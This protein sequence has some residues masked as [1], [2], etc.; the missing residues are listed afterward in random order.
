MKKNTIY[1]LFFFCLITCTLPTSSQAGHNSNFD[2]NTRLLYWVGGAGDWTDPLHWSLSSGGTGGQ[3]PPTSEDDVVFDGQSGFVPGD[4]VAVGANLQACKS[5]DWH[6]VTGMPVF[7]SMYPINVYGSLHLSANM[8]ITSG[9]FFFQAQSG[10]HDITTE[11]QNMGS[12]AFL[13]IGNTW[14][15]QDAF[16]ADFVN[17]GYGTI[18]TNN[19]TVTVGRW[20][21]SNVEAF[22]PNMELFLGTSNLIVANTAD[23]VILFY[24]PGKC[25][26]ENADL[27]FQHGGTLIAE[28][29]IFFQ[30]I[31]FLDATQTGYLNEGNV[32]GKLLF[33]GYGVIHYYGPHFIHEAEFQQGGAFYGS[34]TFDV[35]TLTPGR[36]YLFFGGSTQ[37]ITPGGTINGL[38]GVDCTDRMY[39]HSMVNGQPAYLYKD[40]ADLVFNWLDVRDISVS[41]S[42]QFIANNSAIYGSSAGWTSNY[43]P[44]KL[45]WVNGSGNWSDIS[46]WEDEFGVGNQCPPTALDNVFFDQNSGLSG[47]G[48]IT[49]DVT[50]TCKNLDFTGTTGNPLL[51]FNN[52]LS[53]YGSLTLVTDMQ[54]ALPNWVFGST[55]PG[56]TI[57]S[58]GHNLG[59]VQFLGIGG[60]WTFQ[61]PLEADYVNHGY[62]TIFTN[63]HSVTTGNWQR[64][65]P[66]AFNPYTELFL[67]SST[68]TITSP[69]TQVVLFYAIGKCHSENADLIFEHG[70]TLVAEDGVTFH[71]ISFLDPNYQGFLNEGNVTGKLLFEGYGA[72]YYFGP[73]IIHEAEFQQDGAFYG[74]STFDI[75][76]LTPGKSYLFNSNT[77]QT[78]T[79]CGLLDAVGTSSDPIQMS[80][81]N[82]GE[83]AIIEKNGIRLCVD[84]VNMS[85]IHKSGT[86]PFFA[87][88]NSTDGGNNAGWNFS[89]CPAFGVPVPELCDGIDN[90]CDGDVDEGLSVSL[91]LD[92][93]YDCLSPGENIEIIWSGGCPNWTVDLTLYRISP[94]VA[95]T[96]IA[97]NIPNT[98]SFAWTIPGGVSLSD[99]H[100]YIKKSTAPVVDDYG[101]SFTINNAAS[102]Y[103]DADGDG[104]GDPNNAVEACTSPIGYVADNTDCDDGND[105]VY[106]GSGQPSPVCISNRIVSIAANGSYQL[107]PGQLLLAGELPCGATASLDV[108]DF[109]CADVTTIL[110]P[111]QNYSLAFDGTNEFVSIA[112]PFSGTGNY[113]VEAWFKSENTGNCS[114][115][116]TYKRLLGWGTAQLE[117]ADCGGIL[118]FRAGGLWQSTTVN[119]RDNIWHHVAAV[120]QGNRHIV[121]VDGVKKLDFSQTPAN[122][123]GSFYIGRGSSGSALWK[124][125]IDECRVW[126]IARSQADILGW[127]NKPLP[128]AQAGL[129]GYWNF[130]GGPGSSSLLSN[131]GGPSGVMANM[132]PALDWFGGA[133]LQY[134]APIPVVATINDGGSITTCAS[135]ITV[136]DAQAPVLQC[137]STYTVFPGTAINVLDLLDNPTTDNCGILFQG[138]D[139]GSFTCAEIGVQNVTVT[140]VDINSNQATC[141]VPVTVQD[142]FQYSC[143]DAVKELSAVGLALLNPNDIVTLTPSACGVYG[144]SLSQTLFDC[145]DVGINSV[146]ATISNGA[147]STFSCVVNVTI[148]DV[149][150]PVVT[151]QPF[152]LPLNAAGNATLTPQQVLSSATDAC[153]IAGYSLDINQFDC[154][155]VGQQAVILTATDNN[156]LSASCTATVTV[157][158]NQGPVLNC[159]NVE[160]DLNANGE[161]SLTAAMVSP[162][163]TDNCGLAGTSLTQ[164][165]FDCDNITPDPPYYALNFTGTNN[166]YVNFPSAISGPGNFTF[167]AWFIDNN[168]GSVP[169]YLVGW[170]NAFFELFDIN[171]LL[172]ARFGGSVVNTNVNIRDGVWHH[173]A[174]TRSGS[175]VTIFLDGNIIWTGTRNFNLGLSFQLGRKWSASP[176]TQGPWMGKIDEL[177]FW[178]TA[179][180]QAQ[181]QAAM[182]TLLQGTEVWLAGY[183]P[184][185]D[186]PGNMSVQDAS[187]NNNHGILSGVMSPATA[188]VSGAP[189]QSPGTVVP[190]TLTA[191]DINGQVSNCTVAVTIDYDQ[192]DLVAQCK[193]TTVTLGPDG[194][195]TLLPSQIDNGSSASCGIPSMS[196]APNTFD[197]TTTGVHSVTLTVTDYNGA[198]ATCTSVVT[199][200]SPE[201]DLDIYLYYPPLICSGTSYDLC[202]IGIVSGSSGLSSYSWHSDL[203]PNSSNQISGCEVSPTA[204][205]TIYAALVDG[206]G[207]TFIRSFELEVITSPDISVVPPGAICPGETVDLAALAVTDANNTGASL[208]Y[209]S[210]T[211]AGPG[212]ELPSPLVS[213]AA[214]TTYYILA[215]APNGCKDEAPVTVMTGGTVQAECRDITVY[216]D[217]NGEYLLVASQ[218]DDGSTSSCGSVTFS[219]SPSLFSCSDLGDN[220]VT[221]TATGPG[222]ATATC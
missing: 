89:A 85:D 122:V 18:N 180:T 126:N 88:A 177:R 59:S 91:S 87:G 205:T 100:I 70:G 199:V 113:T 25:H 38:V 185:N 77:T 94:N 154:S 19:H 6:L 78:I 75:L 1:T 29:G 146:T 141:I 51:L 194:T 219:A 112:S 174:V 221:L 131:I 206:Y 31:S 48:T 60:V 167:E 183:W 64:Y 32:S 17:H 35:L 11:G 44:R 120:R 4:M 118:L 213:P 93:D 151:C 119:V 49:I 65:D 153:G 79:S 40:G 7:S 102:F 164:S 67:G 191:T 165:A 66:E 214:T 133:P 99:Y 125:R 45:Y 134:L 169:K 16:R 124:G 170:Q 203:P 56:R 139:R 2:T 182:S 9:A 142:G 168:T 144:I 195:Y 150:P 26:S 123:S 27:V 186:G 190:V 22:N 53:V 215:T 179:R 92:Y 121:Y 15:F 157:S 104:Y 47:G 216:L 72:I 42:A 110:S 173:V 116:N 166:Y 181:I 46:H 97:Q 220:A 138:A 162:T 143:Q 33:E 158:D 84:W 196:A 50:A 197:C 5:M 52:S 36:E 204:N 95:E 192:Q 86:A 108:T 83:A 172:Y 62:G 200:L 21:S 171:G 198:T 8:S 155:D 187:I 159:Q 145:T 163:I 202:G 176:S 68:L 23:Q 212:N 37:T 30:N 209:H 137:K 103:A 136:V 41:G 76:R 207:C 218:I 140:A 34:S 61:D 69:G 81:T 147:G 3:L 201:S 115:V 217:S 82:P 130:D 161:A 74:A 109:D 12:V 128:G 43:Q 160:L 127:K 193:N 149:T 152:T 105:Q 184:M 90:D 178:S 208:T 55:G 20:D 188:W 156:G 71:N 106:P 14:N 132:E 175:T 28:D 24:A 117:F 96:I 98:G 210:A 222:G 211:P 135:L 63:N 114:G 54:L 111:R 148:S 57:T 13:G 101:D 58:G 10:S 80:S 39:L 129:V 189:V 107:T 73:H